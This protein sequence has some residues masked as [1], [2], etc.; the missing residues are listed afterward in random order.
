MFQTMPINLSQ[1][2]TPSL[3]AIEHSARL[4]ELIR[5]KIKNKGPL[6]FADFMQTALYWPGFGY[7]SAGCQKFGKAGDF[8]TAPEISPLF[9][10]CLARQCRQILHELGTGDILEFGA[11]SG[12]M[13][14]DLLQELATTQSLPQ[15]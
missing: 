9:S 10:R 13:A 5:Q 4:L 1:L 11:G 6:S 15:H 7:Y 12:V 3:H 8:V 14:A 2:P